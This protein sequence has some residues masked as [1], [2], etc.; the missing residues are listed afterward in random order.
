MKNKGTL[1]L[2][3]LLC[4]FISL[5]IFSSCSK[6]KT[7]AKLVGKWKLVDVTALS[8]T[9]KALYET[10]EFTED[11]KFLY[12]YKRKVNLHDSI[13]TYAG[14]YSVDKYNKITIWAFDG[15]FEYLN[16]TWSLVRCK[17]GNMMLVNDL[18]GLYFREFTK[19]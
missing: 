1:L 12:S 6:S 3:L 18:G 2:S 10:W 11:F 19:L 9:T 4:V 13:Y 8:D 14:K 5:V 7:N 17:D 16:G 15:S